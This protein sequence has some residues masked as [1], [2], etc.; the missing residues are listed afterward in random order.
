M[1]KVDYLLILYYVVYLI[2]LMAKN[3]YRNRPRSRIE[4]SSVPGTF[5][6]R[7]IEISTRIPMG[8]PMTQIQ[9]DELPR[10]DLLKPPS[11]ATSAEPRWRPQW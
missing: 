8:H 9:I 11:P 5:I 1:A 4:I 2:P 7:D 6:V 10:A 3:G